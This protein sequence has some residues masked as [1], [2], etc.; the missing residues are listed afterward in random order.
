MV[1]ATSEDPLHVFLGALGEAWERLDGTSEAAVYGSI[2]WGSPSFSAWDPIGAG[3]FSEAVIPKG[4][5]LILRIPSDMQGHAFRVTP[6]KLKNNDYS[7]IDS[8]AAARAKVMQQW[9]I[10]LEGGPD[11]VTDSSAVD[12]INFKMKYELTSNGTIKTM[13]VHRNPCQTLS[14][15]YLLDVGCRNPSKVD[16]A[17]QPSCDCKPNSQNC[18]FN[19]CSRILFDIPQTLERYFN[20]FDTGNVVKA[21]INQSSHLK[22]GS[23]LRNYCEDLQNN[24]GD[25]TSY[26]YD[27][28]D[29]SSSPWLNSPH[30]M[31][32]TYQDL[33]T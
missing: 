11:V 8:S 19:E 4:G 28:N 5:F 13:E 3:L 32:V 21:F 14:S 9:P 22:S 27:Y 16:C 30:K 24:S 31:K 2:K 12:G 18:K 26:C 17:S 10:L 25:F 23:S 1:N 15:K 6:L 29:I 33:M 20:E 7:Q